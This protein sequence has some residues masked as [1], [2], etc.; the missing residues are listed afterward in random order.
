MAQGDVTERSTERG[1]EGR[2]GRGRG[3]GRVERVGEAFISQGW[4]FCS[5]AVTSGKQVTSDFSL[6]IL[7]MKSL[8]VPGEQLP[9]KVDLLVVSTAK[10]ADYT[11]G[12]WV[13]RIQSQRE[14]L[15]EPEGEK[16][17]DQ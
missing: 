2:K 6:L 10:N 1:G 7:N 3:R 8:K 16:L 11:D 12:K 9:R 14:L 15:K 5:K 17:R 13:R 4:Q